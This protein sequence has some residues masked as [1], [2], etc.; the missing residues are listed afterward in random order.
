[1]RSNI[2][3]FVLLFAALAMLPLGGCELGTQF[4]IV[5]PDFESAEVEGIW[6]WREDAGGDFARD[7]EIKLGE[8]FVEDG[9]ELVEYTFVDPDTEFELQFAAPV[10]RDAVNPDQAE[11]DL[12]A[13]LWAG[14]GTFKASTYNEFGESPL[15]EQTVETL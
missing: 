11:L 6:I 8:P 7:V 2:R 4:R 5:I 13:L 9:V 1:M 12:F 15:S 10:V 14:V 3:L